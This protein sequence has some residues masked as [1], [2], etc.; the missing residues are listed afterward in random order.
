MSVA[1]SAL[2]SRPACSACAAASGCPN[3]SRGDPCRERRDAIGLL[4]IAAELLV[5]Q[6]RRQPID[7]RLERRLAVLVPEEARVAQPRRQ[8]ALGVARDDLR[9]LRLHVR[10]GEKRR[11]QLAVVVHHREVVLVMNHRRRQHF[12]GQLEELDRECARRRR[13]DTRRGRAPPAAAT[14]AP[15]PVALTAAAQLARVR[16]ELAADLRLA[17]AAIEDDEV[18]EQPRLVVLERL[19]LDRAA[20]AAA[21]RQEPMAVGV[22][23]RA[24]VL[25]RRSLRQLGSADDERARRGRRRGGPAS[26]SA[27]RTPDRPCRPRGTRPS[28]SASE[29]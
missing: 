15:R 16:L 3:A 18:L 5:E 25:H 24:D 2:H 8:H 12:F 27:A 14:T 11:L 22:R 28:A 1:R 20:G 17:L 10:H 7:A 9:L 19:D 4:A 21:R 29:T 13:T 23:T 26:E 6:D